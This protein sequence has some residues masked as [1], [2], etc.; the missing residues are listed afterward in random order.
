MSDNKPYDVVIVGGGHN[1][2]VCACYLARA[3][4]KVVVLERREIL[5]GAAVTEE[6]HPG[7]RNSV[8]SYTVSLLHPKII[9]DLRLSRH[10]LRIVERP[11][12]NFMP[13]PDGRY[14]S[15]GADAASDSEQISNFSK[16]DAAS[17]PRYYEML[18]GVVGLLRATLLET[19]PNAGG[20]L[21]DAWR[22]LKSGRRWL[23]LNLEQQRS[24][25][26]LMS[27]SAGEILE[28]W[29][30]TPALKALFGFDAIVGNFASPYHPGTG[31]VLL[32]HVF[33]EVNGK[34]GAWGHAIGGMGAIT[35]A[36]AAEARELGVELRTA[37]PIAEILVENSRVTGVRSADGEEFRARQV[38]ANLNPKL[39]FLDLI[40]EAELAPEFLESI[41]G[42]RCGSGTFRMNVALSELPDF[43]CLPGTTQGRHHGGGIIMGPSLEYMHDAYEDARKNGWSKRPVVEMLIPSTIDDSLAP[44][45]NHVASLFCQHF[46]PT[47]PDGKQWDECRDAA[48]ETIIDTVTEYAPNFRSSIVGR[49]VLSPADLERKFGLVGGD[50]FHGRLSMEQLYSARPLLGYGNYRT[51]IRNLY[52]CGSG[53][54]PGGGV[55]GLPGH[56]A[57]REILRDKRP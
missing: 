55:T 46:S 9:A 27:R 1:G 44:P 20:G 53:T 23:N 57:A 19:P 32:H 56:N 29:F 34:Q 17:L 24:V 52:M 28:D 5:G 41:K 45:G 25:L 26:Q 14:L 48:A 3:G 47:L 2:L 42:F 31:Y 33:G 22:A 39:L 21:I 30:E 13:L 38:A 6:F 43:S 35:Q 51:P 7:F 50:I 40:Q 11:L 12:A 36:M 16:K 4:R 37:T 49:M 10:G 15:F 54:H 18:D 8:A